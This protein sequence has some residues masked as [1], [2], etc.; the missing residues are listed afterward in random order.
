M[1]RSPIFKE[2]ARANR[3]HRKPMGSND[4]IIPMN[5]VYSVE[6]P[7][8]WTSHS[9]GNPALRASNVAADE[10]R[11]LSRFGG[12]VYRVFDPTIQTPGST[13]L[14]DSDDRETNMVSPGHDSAIYPASRA[15]PACHDSAT[16]TSRLY[17]LPAA[18]SGT[19]RTPT[20]HPTRL[21]PRTTPRAARTP[22]RHQAAECRP[23]GAVFPIDGLDRPAI[24]C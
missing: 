14:R 2:V 1:S 9:H 24:A 17:S 20:R 21:P 19:R 18:S 15:L 13:R 8:H 6:P 5:R 16:Q 3:P 7:S 4:R 12:P 10:V 23:P 22:R 11:P